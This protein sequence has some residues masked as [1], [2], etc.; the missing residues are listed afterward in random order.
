MHTSDE[1][2]LAYCLIEGRVIF[3]QD[4]D[5]LRLHAAGVRHAGIVYCA[6]DTKSIGRIIQGLILIRELLEPDDM[7]SRVEFL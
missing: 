3:S 7:A 1:E 6:K 5:F 4:Q 2:Q